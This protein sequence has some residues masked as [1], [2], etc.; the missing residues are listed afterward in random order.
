[1]EADIKR[2]LKKRV[3]IRELNSHTPLAIVVP[4]APHH[5]NRVGRGPL[6]IKIHVFSLSGVWLDLSATQKLLAADHQR[7][8]CTVFK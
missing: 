4:Y 5:C 2:T 7:N 8:N 3:S 1:M 6:L